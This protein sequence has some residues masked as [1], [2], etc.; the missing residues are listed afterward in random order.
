K[1]SAVADGAHVDLPRAHNRP[2]VRKVRGD[3]D[4]RTGGKLLDLRVWAGPD[5]VEDRA[6]HV[7]SDEREDVVR[8]LECRRDVRGV[9]EMAVEHEAVRFLRDGDRMEVLRVCPMGNQVH[10]GLW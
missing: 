5:Q 3:P 4:S 8:E 1:A 9:P 6:G 2:Q 10:T 7:L